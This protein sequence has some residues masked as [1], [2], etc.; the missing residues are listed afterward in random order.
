MTRIVSL[1]VIGSCMTVLILGL[2]FTNQI[3]TNIENACAARNGVLLGHSCVKSE[4][5]INLNDGKVQ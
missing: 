4:S 1:L 5:V 3:Y 2:R